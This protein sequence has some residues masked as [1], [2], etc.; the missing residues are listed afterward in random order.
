[1]GHRQSTQQADLMTAPLSAQQVV[2]AYQDLRAPRPAATFRQST[3]PL[4]HL[5]PLM[6]R[7][8]LF[9][10]DAFGV[11]NVGNHAIPGA[12]ARLQALRELGKKVMMVSN[13]SSQ[14]APHLLEKYKKMGFSF[15]AETLVCSRDVLSAHWHAHHRFQAGLMA[16]DEGALF[17]LP[18]SHHRLQDTRQAYDMAEIFVLLGSADWTHS[19][20]ALLEQALRQQHRPVWVANPDLVA[21]R[22]HGFSLEPGYFANELHRTTGCSMAFFGKPHAGIFELALRIAGYQGPAERVLMVGDTLHTDVLGGRAM[23]FDTALVTGFG[24]CHGLDLQETVDRT[25]ICPD[26]DMPFI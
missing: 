20:Q 15:T 3:Q 11:L 18:T 1:M 2:Q 25:G 13:A 14:P 19:R 7:Y 23:G 16:P 12:V 26:F 21:P 4:P 24:A 5:G 22:E 8:D 17:D 9:L 10:F 6:D